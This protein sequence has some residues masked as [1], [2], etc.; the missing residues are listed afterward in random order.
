MHSHTLQ[1]LCAIAGLRAARFAA[2]VMV[3]LLSLGALA[4]TAR[5]QP[6]APEDVVRQFYAVL[7]QTMQNGPTLGPQ[8]RYQ[9]L[10]PVVRNDFDLPSMTRLA[11]GVAWSRLSPQEQQQVTDGFARYITASYAQNF[12]SYSGEKLEVTGARKSGYGAIV[13]TRIVKPDGEPVTINYLMHDNA[14]TW[15]IADVYLTGTISQVA[16]LH[17]QF[18]SI[19]SCQGVNGLIATLNR[20]ADMLVASAE[21]R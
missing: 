18:A 4:D 12:D 1:R 20:K 8:G 21:P 6:P 13:E 15:Q 2:V 10:A 5:A 14:G 16:N 3:A 7:L 19:L 11:V 9:Q 17:S